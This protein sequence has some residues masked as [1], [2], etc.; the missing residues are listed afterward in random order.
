VSLRAYNKMTLHSSGLFSV[1]TASGCIDNTL[2]LPVSPFLP[3]EK[4]LAFVAT[5]HSV[6]GSKRDDSESV[7]I[8]FWAGLDSD[9]DNK[10]GTGRTHF[11]SQPTRN[12]CLDKC[13]VL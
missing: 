4:T 10:G 7:R 11:A 5:I 13:E 1:R 3:D 12:N 2:V 8:F 6:R 9:R